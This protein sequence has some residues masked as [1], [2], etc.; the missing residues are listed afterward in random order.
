[1]SMLMTMTES[2]V[3]ADLNRTDYENGKERWDRI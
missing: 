1:M 2:Q 3:R